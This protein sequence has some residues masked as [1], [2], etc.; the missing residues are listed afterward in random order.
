[1]SSHD[2]DVNLFSQALSHISE[3]LSFPH[4]VPIYNCTLTHYF[5]PSLRANV[6]CTLYFDSDWPSYTALSKQLDPEQSG[7]L[8]YLQSIQTSSHNDFHDCHKQ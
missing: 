4:Y 8:A 6:Q 1:M 5:I 2:H 7:S 3:S